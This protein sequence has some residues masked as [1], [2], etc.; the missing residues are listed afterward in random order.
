MLERPVLSDEKI[1]ACLRDEYGLKVAKIVF[2]PLGADM[3]TAVFR[4]DADDSTPYFVKLRSGHFDAIAVDVPKFLFDQG[5]SQIIAPMPT[6]SGQ[7][8]ARLD[9]FN[10]ILYPFVEGQSGWEKNLSDQ[11]W[12][13]FG[14]ALKAIHA[15][16]LA[17]TLAT[18]ISQE[19]YSPYWRELVRQFQTQVEAETFADPVAADLAMLLKA[20]QSEINHL[21]KRAEDLGAV[22]RGQRSQFV[23]CHSDI[24]VGNI[25]MNNSSD[26]LYIVDWDQPLLA[27]KERDLMFIGA[28][29]DGRGEYAEHDE[30]LFYEGYGQTAVDPVALAYYRYERIVQDIA[31]YCQQLLLTDE[32][33]EDRREG[34]RQ[35]TSQ[36]QPGAVIDIAYRTEKRLPPELQSKL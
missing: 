13:V 18:R 28:G 26:D 8:S 4:A 33:G 12:I 17:P 16:I 31:A 1:I 9:A 23:L 27:P 25:L 29:I 14:R 10:L 20:K 7:L 19:T 32:G 36:F 2:L 21:I 34:L 24:H 11:D 30:R 15:T 3:N 22:L 35:I 5:I 6:R